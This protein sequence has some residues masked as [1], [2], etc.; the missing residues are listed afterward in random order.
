MKAI[1]LI[2]DSLLALRK[3]D[4]VAAAREFMAEQGVTELPI[5]DKLEVYNYA[6]TMVL[7]DLEGSL[8][9]E[10]AIP[11]NP[12]APKINGEQHLYE[13]VPVF[14]LSDLQVLAV[15]N[16]KNEFVGMIDQRNIHKN[17]SQ[18]L[19]YKG[20]GAV[21]VLKIEPNDFAPSQIARIIEE[22]GAKILGMMVDETPDKSLRV[23]LKL[24]T[25]R[26]RAIVA[27]LDR[28]NI[29]T[30]AC[31]MSEDYNGVSAKEFDSVLKF[32]DL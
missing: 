2:S 20:L 19:T 1:S 12:H 31:Y 25:T 8:R 4:T 3:T 32:F 23:N 7:A 27:S 13:I 5:L 21:I 28:Y 9:L 18:S 10:E 30:E 15:V 24:N 11:Y 17:I 26:V 14:A 29:K 6:R 16:E 22:N